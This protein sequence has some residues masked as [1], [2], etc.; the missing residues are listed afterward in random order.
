VPAA[1]AC[2]D[3]VLTV[4][5][6]G[7]VAL[8]P[9]SDGAVTAGK[10]SG[11]CGREGGARRECLDPGRDKVASGMGG[12]CRPRRAWPARGRRPLTCGPGREEI[13]GRQVGPMDNPF[14]I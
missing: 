8:G 3:Q 10:L 13:G 9:R 14:Q 12:S 11:E 6:V 5:V 1:V 4:L 7:L 2:L